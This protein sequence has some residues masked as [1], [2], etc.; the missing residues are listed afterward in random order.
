[1]KECVGFKRDEASEGRRKEMRGGRG[2]GGEEEGR[3]KA[4][5]GG[6]WD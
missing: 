3:E 1:M 2:M 5:E 6:A 4:A